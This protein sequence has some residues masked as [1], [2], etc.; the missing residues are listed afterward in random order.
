MAD[1]KIPVVEDEK[2]SPLIEKVICAKAI[3]Y[4]YCFKAFLHFSLLILLLNYLDPED[5]AAVYYL[6]W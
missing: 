4:C 6:R 3:V 2:V 5:L 1:K